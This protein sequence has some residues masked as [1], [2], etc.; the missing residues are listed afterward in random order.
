MSNVQTLLK[1]AEMDLRDVAAVTA[2]LA[3][4][5]DYARFNV[6]REFFKVQ[7]LPTRSTVAVK[8]LARHARV[9]MTLTAVRCR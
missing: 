7:P 5:S 1:A 8:A 2:Y 3:D 4:M 6:Y 9:E